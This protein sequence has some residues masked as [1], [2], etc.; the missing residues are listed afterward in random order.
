MAFREC[1]ARH[2]GAGRSQQVRLLGGLAGGERSRR[3]QGAGVTPGNVQDRTNGCRAVVGWRGSALRVERH[4]ARTKNAARAQSNRPKHGSESTA[5]RTGW[6][7]VKARAKPAGAGRRYRKRIIGEPWW[8]VMTHLPPCRSNMLVAIVLARGRGRGGQVG[9]NRQRP[10]GGGAAGP[11]PQGLGNQ[12]T[13][14]AHAHTHTHT[15]HTH[16]ARTH[17]RTHPPPRHTHT[18]TCPVRR[19]RPPARC[20]S[21]SRGRPRQT[22]AR[23][24]P[25]S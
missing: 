12:N 9:G 10:P 1:E 24:Q 11:A 19:Q 16:Q 17:A 6:L 21:P 7:W 20:T 5:P 3:A 8:W 2:A 4:T 22:R 13:N 14:G 25:R 18:H 15:S 23:P